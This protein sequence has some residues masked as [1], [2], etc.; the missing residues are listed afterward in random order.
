[1]EIR[2]NGKVASMTHGF[3]MPGTLAACS[4]SAAALASLSSWKR[5]A[6]SEALPDCSREVIRKSRR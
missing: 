4:L 2:L 6:L 5:S 1:M 3:N